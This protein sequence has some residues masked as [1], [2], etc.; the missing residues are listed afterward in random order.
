MAD[1]INNP[2]YFYNISRDDAQFYL[3]STEAG[4]FL[5]RDSSKEGCLVIS[6]K[7][8]QKVLHLL[9]L[10]K[11][12]GG[13]CVDPEAWKNHQ[14]GALTFPSLELLI[15]KLRQLKMLK[16]GLNQNLVVSFIQ[17]GKSPQEAGV[18]AAHSDG[19]EAQIDK[20]LLG[21]QGKEEMKRILAQSA[22]EASE[23]E[24]KGMLT[25]MMMTRHLQSDD[26]QMLA[27]WREAHHLSEA[28][29]IK[30]LKSLNID[31][32]EFEHMKDFTEKVDDRNAC[33]IC[34]DQPK[35]AVFVDCGH[36]AA[37]FSCAEK[38]AECPLCRHPRGK[39]LRVF[40]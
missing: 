40:T 20:E 36:L 38:L 21:L 26:V 12:E 33:V 28:Q 13:F 4:T 35:S 39:I 7:Q 8:S 2:Y 24:Y 37:C 19:Q 15:S 27:R 11:A 23:H 30:V 9:I 6:L 17:Q 5:V 32:S 29:H 10:R 14:I 1:V 25:A 3:E 22:A 31:P 16:N 34:M 18:A